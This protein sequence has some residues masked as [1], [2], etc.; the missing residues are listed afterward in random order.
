M[1]LE[2]IIQSEV[3]QK[4]KSKYRNAYI[5]S[6]ERQLLM[7]LPAG[8]QWRHRHGGQMGTWVAGEKGKGGMDGESSME[9]QILPYITD[10]QRETAVWLTELTPGLCNNNGVGWGG[11]VQRGVH[12][13]TYGR[14][15]LLYGRNQHNNINQVSFS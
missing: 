7:N 2:P 15:M 11:R 3:S 9:T 14:F 4:E 6:L 1:N 10:S 13:H 12:V 8:Q 5:W